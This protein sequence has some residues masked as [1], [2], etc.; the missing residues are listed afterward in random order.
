ME[1]ELS[2]EVEEFI[3]SWDKMQYYHEKLASIVGEKCQQALKDRGI[4]CNV[5]WR[6]KEADSLKR[7]IYTR[8]HPNKPKFQ[9]EKDIVE[10][11]TDLAGVRIALYWPEHKKMVPNILESF[12]RIKK[13]KSV[14]DSDNQDE[15]ARRRARRF[16]WYSADHY[17][18]GLKQEQGVKIGNEEDNIEVQVVTVLRNAL[19]EVEHNLV[20]KPL[21]GVPSW[22]EHNI[23]DGLSGVIY[24]GE[25]FLDQLWDSRARKSEDTKEPFENI[26]DL[27]LCLSRLVSDNVQSEDSDLGS[28]RPLLPL[29][30]IYSLNSPFELKELLASMNSQKVRS[31][32]K[33][34]YGD[35]Q[36]TMSVCIMDYILFQRDSARIRKEQ[37][38]TG[39]NELEKIYTTFIWL[40]ELFPPSTSWFGPL[41]LKNNL[42][43]NENSALLQAFKWLGQSTTQDLLT[44]P[45]K[46]THNAR[47]QLCEL[48]SWFGRH[49]ERPIQLASQ[50]CEL[51]IVRDLKK[52]WHLFTRAFAI[53]DIIE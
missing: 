12:V 27:G 17:I 44:N 26:Y 15:Q 10:D 3:K 47:N 20:Y 14:S 22:E 39:G 52:E 34:A 2:R 50:L 25:C 30:E 19:A 6:V 5:S 9:S 35:I 8:Q 13:N 41:L 7:K 29:L 51:N 11:I 38:S 31:H 45:E 32:I 21:S 18:V 23:I 42:P 49:R 43:E 40:D 16:Q 37:S 24:M 53:L 1:G 46:M 28:L 4:P 48:W 33:A 36:P